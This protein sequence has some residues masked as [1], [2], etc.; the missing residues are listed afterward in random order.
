MSNK[1]K[2]VNNVVKNTTTKALKFANATVQTLDALRK[3]RETWEATDY[4]KAN[5]GLYAL[6][7]DTHAIYNDRF[8][9]ASNDERKQL[10]ADLAA[11]LVADGI[12]VQKNT[13]TLTMLVRYVFGSDRKRAHGYAYVLKAAVSHGVVPGNLATYIAEQGGIEEIKRKMVV[14][15]KALE[16]RSEIDK[17]KAEVIAAL[18]AADKKP[19]AKVKLAGL[20]GKYAILLAKPG[21]DGETAVIGTLSDV[22][23]ALYN[24]LVNK[25]AKVKAA[26]NEQA[27]IVNKEATDLM[28]HAAANDEDDLEEKLTA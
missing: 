11:R 3:R 7:A 18:E 9:K 6:L 26:A 12:K 19:L 24:A 16:R 28:A 14:S 25:L 20:Q 21:V 13:V 15:E 1:Q 23:D 8:L 4:K 22:D 17:A 27:A 5:D 10:R 2:A